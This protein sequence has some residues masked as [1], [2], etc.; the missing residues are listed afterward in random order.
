MRVCPGDFL[1]FSCEIRDSSILAWESDEY[2]G[3][4]GK[5]L[6]FLSAEPAGT[7][8]SSGG[9]SEVVA[10]LIDSYSENGIQVLNSKLT[11]TELFQ[12]HDGVIEV[13]CVNVGL[14]TKKA[15]GLT[16]KGM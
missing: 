16:G 12:H 14:D 1:T 10:T 7:T 9:D 8:K 3:R 13:V 4:H 11:V 5:R 2:I 6:E 15:L